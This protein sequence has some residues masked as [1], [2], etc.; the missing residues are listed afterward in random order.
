[1]ATNSRWDSGIMQKIIWKYEHES[2]KVAF[3]VDLDFTTHK[4]LFL[5]W[6]R[7]MN[8]IGYILDSTEMEE[9]WDG[10]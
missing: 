5:M 7:F 6:V 9:M 2:E 8:A 1:M 3:E 10:K 4:D